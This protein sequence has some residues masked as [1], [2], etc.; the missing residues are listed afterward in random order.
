M[1][2]TIIH[3]F[4]CEKPTTMSPGAKLSPSKPNWHH[5]PN[6]DI[7]F[8][9]GTMEMLSSLLLLPL[10]HQNIPDGCIIPCYPQNIWFPARNPPQCT[11][12]STTQPP[13][14]ALFTCIYWCP[15]PPS[16]SPTLLYT[17]ALPSG[18]L[19]ISSTLPAHPKDSIT[20]P[21]QPQHHGNTLFYSLFL[22]G[23]QVP[24]WIY[25]VC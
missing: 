20:N 21:N 24:L 17:P 19:G 8:K 23:G 15:Q 11:Q 25:E 10:E 13:L 4:F 3:S 9:F 7:I 1:I 12:Q 18:T 6:W 14:L 2:A 5:L 22:G 16:N